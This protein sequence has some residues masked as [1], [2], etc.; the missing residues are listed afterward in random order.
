LLASH[1]ALVSTAIK[2]QVDTR[3]KLDIFHE[4]KDQKG[5][6]RAA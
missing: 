6:F 2:L 5:S 3:S 1:T 4:K